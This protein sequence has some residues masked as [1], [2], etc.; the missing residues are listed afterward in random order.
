MKRKFLS[1]ALLPALALSLAVLLGHP[2]H[3]LAQDQ[4]LEATTSTGEKVKLFPNGRWE[5]A[6]EQKAAVQRQAAAAETQRERS[7]E[8]GWF[9]TRK[10]YEG[11]KDYNRGSLNPKM[12]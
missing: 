5:Y 8:G 3:L 2:G 1:R 9:G 11:D 10:I 6:N 7:S 4:P 12:H